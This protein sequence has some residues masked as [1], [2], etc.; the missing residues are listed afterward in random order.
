MVLGEI[1]NPPG[2]AL[3]KVEKLA[4][5]EIGYSKEDNGLT[6]AERPGGARIGGNTQTGSNPLGL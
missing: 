6:D 3:L 5:D 4:K 1:G 2:E